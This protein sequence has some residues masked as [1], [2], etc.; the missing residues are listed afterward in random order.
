MLQLYPFFASRHTKNILSPLGVHSTRWFLYFWSGLR[1]DSLSLPERNICL[2]CWSKR[3]FFEKKIILGPLFSLRILHCNPLAYSQK[4]K[5]VRSL[6]PVQLLGGVQ[7]VADHLPMIGGLFPSLL[8]TDVGILSQAEPKRRLKSCAISPPQ[9]PPPRQWH[10][11]QLLPHCFGKQW[12][13]ERGGTA[14]A[15]FKPL[16]QLLPVVSCANGV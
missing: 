15:G 16:D 2:R 5:C 8:N 14:R 1:T 6:L 11:Q 4:R 13:G 10:P 7:S 12:E 3:F 9:T